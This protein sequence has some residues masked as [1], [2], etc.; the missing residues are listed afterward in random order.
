MHQ[1]PGKEVTKLLDLSDDLL[2][3]VY[4]ALDT[5]SKDK[6]VGSFCCWSSSTLTIFL[7]PVTLIP[8][9]QLC[10]FDVA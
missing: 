9:F 7:P 10:K 5:T 8:L 6:E 2:G 4:A 3:L 1:K